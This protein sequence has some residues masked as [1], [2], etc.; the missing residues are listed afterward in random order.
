[1]EKTRG[2]VSKV[3]LWFLTSFFILLSISALPSISSVFGFLFVVL[4]IP[5][6]KWQ[7]PI[8][9]FINTKIKRIVSAALVVAF[10]VFMPASV[11][12]DINDKDT[13]TTINTTTTTAKPT[14]RKTTTVITQAQEITYILNIRSMKFHYSDC[15]SAKRISDK[16]MD[17]HTGTRDELL[18]I[19]YTPCGNCNP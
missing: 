5:I 17:T 6:E 19:R 7:N 10:F 3:L 11:P 13:V 14:T 8:K 12:E 1:M 16:N 2:I 15:A 4:I 9:R 18:D